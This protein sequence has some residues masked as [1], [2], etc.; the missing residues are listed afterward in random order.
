L[1]AN[2]LARQLED[3][4]DFFYQ[5]H[6]LRWLQTAEGVQLDGIGD[7]VVLSRME[8]LALSNLGGLNIPID[9]PT[10]RL[11]GLCQ[12]GCRLQRKIGDKD[13]LWLLE[14]IIHGECAFGLPLDVSIAEVT[15]SIRLADVRMPIVGGAGAP[16]RRH[17]N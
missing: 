3:V 4:Y 14:R 9:D 8:A 5:L 17:K 10:Y 15:D 12:Y 2:R 7:I 11:W 16:D 6:T 13:L 1:T